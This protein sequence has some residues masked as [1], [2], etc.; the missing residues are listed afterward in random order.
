MDDQP[1][2]AD[3]PVEAPVRQREQ[4]EVAERYG[5]SGRHETPVI[6]FAC[7]ASIRSIVPRNAEVPCDTVSLGFALAT[8]SARAD[9]DTA[10]R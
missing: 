8:T 3:P 4:P 5:T 6:R 7:A 9:H 1:A 10:R 2:R